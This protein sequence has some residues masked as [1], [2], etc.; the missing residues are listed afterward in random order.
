MTELRFERTC[1]EGFTESLSRL[2]DHGGSMLSLDSGHIS[3]EWIDIFTTLCTIWHF[4][5]HLDH[6]G[7][8]IH[9]KDYTY[10][11]LEVCND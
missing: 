7:V 6:E 11:I 4:S 2:K 5:R 1:K 3:E 10:S 8:S 9:A